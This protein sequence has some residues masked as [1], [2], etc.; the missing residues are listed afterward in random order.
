MTLQNVLKN[1]FMFSACAWLS[2]CSSAVFPEVIE[3]DSMVMSES[4]SGEKVIKEGKAL[5]SDEKNAAYEDM[6]SEDDVFAD[7]VPAKDKDKTANVENKQSSKDEKKVATKD[8][9]KKVVAE[10]EPIKPLVETKPV[11]QKPMPSQNA[12]NVLE[13]QMGEPE[14]EPSVTYRLE[15]IYFDNGSAYVSPEY[16]AKLREAANLVKNNN[17]RIRVL[18]YASSRTRNTDIV[19]HKMANFKISAER[20]ENVAAALRRAGV[21]AKNIATEALSDTAPAYLEVMPEGE[22]LNRRA[23]IYVSY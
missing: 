4:E 12:A 22:R 23:E 19:T 2:A 10:K 7:V 6:P 11:E 17:A 18:G 3:D 16:N 14:F 1:V 20:A 9:E 15:T 5:G 21:P 13:S 8:D